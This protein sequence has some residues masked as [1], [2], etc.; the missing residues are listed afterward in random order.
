MEPNTVDRRRIVLSPLITDMSSACE[1][2]ESRWDKAGTSYGRFPSF[3]HDMRSTLPFDHFDLGQLIEEVDERAHIVA[4]EYTAD[5]QRAHARIV[6]DDS[7]L[8]VAIEFRRDGR[9]GFTLKRD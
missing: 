7:Q 4:L 3:R 5:G 2:N 1:G 6:H 9:N 8:V